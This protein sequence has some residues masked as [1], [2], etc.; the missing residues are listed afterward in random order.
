MRRKQLNYG[1]LKNMPKTGVEPATFALRSI[2][3][4][5]SARRDRT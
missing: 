3:M 1:N 5:L 2:C 4:Q